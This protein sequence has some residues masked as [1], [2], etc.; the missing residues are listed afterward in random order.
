MILKSNCMYYTTVG[1]ILCC[2]LLKTGL[3][4]I[5]NSFKHYSA[6]WSCSCEGNVRYVIATGTLFAKMQQIS[7]WY[8]I[9]VEDMTDKRSDTDRV[10]FKLRRFLA[11][12]GYI[13]N[14]RVV[15]SN[16]C[17]EQYMYYVIMFRLR[18]WGDSG[19]DCDI[20]QAQKCWR[21]TVKVHGTILFNPC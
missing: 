13:S 20:T 16:S 1:T 2:V 17:V 5:S 8:F 19:G 12:R 18:Q 11:N 14:F 21:E 7:S 9:K 10:F 15:F 6:T 4:F 3:T